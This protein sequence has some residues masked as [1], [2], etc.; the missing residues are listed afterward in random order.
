MQSPANLKLTGNNLPD[1]TA[2]RAP[3]APPGLDLLPQ[4]T[5][6]L[7]KRSWADIVKPRNPAVDDACASINASTN[8][9]RA[10][11]EDSSGDETRAESLNSSPE[12]DS[13]CESVHVEKPL[14]GKLNPD[15]ASFTF[16]H[17]DAPVFVPKTISLVETIAH[18]ETNSIAS[19]QV[20]FAVQE[21]TAL[22]CSA[23]LFVPGGMAQ[24]AAPESEE[25][26]YQD[27]QVS[28]VDPPTP[29]GLRP[30]PGLSLPL[31]S[32]AKSFVPLY[33]PLSAGSW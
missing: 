9:H 21:R 31:S 22:R 1:Y 26:G 4:D 30:P 32:K 8:K 18:I 3:S 5:S 33:A 19:G 2:G 10:T 25:W 7:A 16:F 28:V 6:V 15:A 17:A 12:T 24:I 13:D 20:G 14:R 23:S 29:P 27:L 11:S